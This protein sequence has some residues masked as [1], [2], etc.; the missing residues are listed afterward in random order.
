MSALGCGD[1]A[2]TEKLVAAG[3]QVVGVDTSPDMVASARARRLD[4]R[5]MDAKSLDFSSE[6]DAVFTNAVLHWVKDDPD[7]PTAGAFRALK[8]GGRFVGEMGGHACVGAI[9]V[10]LL[11]ALKP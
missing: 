10:A 1:G 6:F 2:L 8:P 4:A 3:A 5:V 7:A 9:T 11:A